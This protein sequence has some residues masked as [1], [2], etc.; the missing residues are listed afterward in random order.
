M[1]SRREHDHL[2]ATC[3]A[4]LDER[5]HATREEVFGA[6]KPATWCA[7]LA[8]KAPTNHC[9]QIFSAGAKTFLNSIVGTERQK[10]DRLCVRERV[11]PTRPRRLRAPE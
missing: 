1:R 3:E 5:D 2:V 11:I 10:D 9:A 8:G 6:I 4:F 7:D